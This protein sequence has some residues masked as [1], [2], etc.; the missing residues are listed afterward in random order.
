[1][2]LVTVGVGQFGNQ[3]SGCVYQ[4]L[5]QQSPFL[6]ER[7]LFDEHGFARAVLVDGEA[8]VVGKLLRDKASPFKSSRA[9]FE[10]S[11]RGN[12][13]ALGYFGSDGNALAE[14]AM[15][16][17][18]QELEI[19]DAYRGC[20]LMHSLCGGTGSGLGSRLIEEIR[21]ELERSYLASVSILPFSIGEL[22]LQN[23]NSIL[24]LS[25]ILAEADT[26]LLFSN[27]AL[28][29]TCARSIAKRD[30]SATG[31]RAAVTPAQC[32]A[33]TVQVEDINHQIALSLAGLAQPCVH[34][35]GACASVRPFDFGDMAQLTPTI[36]TKV[37]ELWSVQE[38]AGTFPPR[39]GTP[40]TIL[41]TALVAKIP[42]YDRHARGI[43]ITLHFCPCVWFQRYLLHV[44]PGTG[45]RTRVCRK[46][47][48]ELLSATPQD[49][50]QIS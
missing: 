9:H 31:S 48:F 5:K 36:E 44:T 4:L 40:W 45:V 2:S 47:I 35:T 1:M 19:C 22:P 37:L 20:M 29:T 41:A 30:A 26:S 11:G 13:W 6:G 38:A 24:C 16:S 12:N 18:R 50:V 25:R 7:Y 33:A 14:K 34:G 23:Y 10:Q 39:V 8:K 32:A 43:L 46:F 49:C 21:D 28:L 27:D 15:D 42:R 3:I 17:F